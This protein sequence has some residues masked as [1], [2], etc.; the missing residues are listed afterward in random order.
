M[1][2]LKS[3]FIRTALRIALLEWPKNMVVR[4]LQFWIWKKYFQ[5]L[6]REV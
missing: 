5:S 4:R 1:R 2:R 6:G 3:L